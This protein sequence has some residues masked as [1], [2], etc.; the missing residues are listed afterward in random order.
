MD[1]PALGLLLRN[2]RRAAGESQ[3]DLAART[4]VGL[5]LITEFERGARPNV[6]LETAVG[7]LTAV[8]V[9]AVFQAA[10]GTEWRAEDAPAA[11]RARAAM[12]RRSWTGH[13]SALHRDAHD[14]PASS[15]DMASNLERTARLST[16]VAALR[17]TA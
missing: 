3:A 2:A 16:T 14:P 15:D 1:L 17:P 7:L 6:S 11:A 8:G 5:R 4:G 10:D 12:R 13:V 9:T